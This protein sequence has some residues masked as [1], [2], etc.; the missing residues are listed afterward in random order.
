M[1]GQMP[2]L[3][4]SGTVY[5]QSLAIQAF[6]GKEF[7]L[8]PTNNRDALMTDQIANA[9]EDLFINEAR[10]FG[11]G[12]TTTVERN[13]TLDKAYPLYF[14]NF[15]MSLSRIPH[16]QD[17]SLVIRCL[18]RTSSSSRAPRPPCSSS[19]PSWTTTRTSRS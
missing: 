12:Q 15:N 5:A 4:I 8:Y 9:R 1:G 18:W 7:G 17:L 19:P 11:P 10:V 2:I 14:N 13:N 3:N 16:S 6:M